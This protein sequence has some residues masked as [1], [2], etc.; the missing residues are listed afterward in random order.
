MGNIL[1]GIFG[2]LKKYVIILI[3]LLI[4]AVLLCTGV[5]LPIDENY[6][7][8]LPIVVISV[9]LV[10]FSVYLSGFFVDIIKAAIK[11]GK[12]GEIKNMFYNPA[13]ASVL[14]LLVSIVSTN[15]SNLLVGDLTVPLP[16]ILSAVRMFL[17]V[18]VLAALFGLFFDI[19]DLSFMYLTEKGKRS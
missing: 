3:S 4:T 7:F 15:A 5:N 16:Y 12:E 10:A 2:L 14:L 13:I 11:L 1:K 6:F 17:T 18:Y 19:F 9:L 8:E